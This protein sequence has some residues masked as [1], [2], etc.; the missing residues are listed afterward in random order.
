MPTC[1]RS[2][3]IA[4]IRPPLPQ[5]AAMEYEINLENLIHMKRVF[6]V[7]RTVTAFPSLEQQ[8]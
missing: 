6:E 1:T 2:P 7:R 4:Q 3:P 8:P 5:P